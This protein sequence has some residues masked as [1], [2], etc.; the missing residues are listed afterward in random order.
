MH[1]VMNAEIKPEFLR[2][3]APRKRCPYTGLSRSTLCELTIPSPKNDHRPPVKSVLIKKRGAI[4]GIRLLVYDNRCLLSLSRVSRG[5]GQHWRLV[6]DMGHCRCALARD[7]GISGRTA[8]V[9][10]GWNGSD[11]QPEC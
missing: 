3:P 8:S 11:W 9:A 10:A 2:L 5:E 1:G 6:R 7:T 4:R